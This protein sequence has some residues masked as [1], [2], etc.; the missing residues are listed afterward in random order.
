MTING[1]DTPYAID[2]SGEAVV[3]A[4]G[5]AGDNTVEVVDDIFGSILSE[6]IA[7]VDCTETTTTTEET[8]TTTEAT[9]TTQRRKRRRPRRRRQPPPR[10]PRRPPPRRKRPSTTG[11]PSTEGTVPVSVLPTVIDQTELPQTG[12]DNGPLAAMGIAMLLGGAGLL[13]AV[14]RQEGMAS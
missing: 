4:N 5:M 2:G 14:R 9:T 13:I 10:K 1:V 12:I 6:I 11:S 8:T 3:A 7:L